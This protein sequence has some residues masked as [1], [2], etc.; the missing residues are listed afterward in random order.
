MYQSGTDAFKNTSQRD[1]Q[2]RKKLMDIYIVVD[3]TQIKAGSQYIWLW[4]AIIKPK[5][6]EILLLIDASFERIICL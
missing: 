3:E 6:R 4:V 5:H 2:L 1:F